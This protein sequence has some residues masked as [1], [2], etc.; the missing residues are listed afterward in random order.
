VGFRP[1]EGVK[2]SLDC[3]V[4]DFL[5]PDQL[6]ISLKGL[7]RAGCR[8]PGRE[9]RFVF[10]VLRI[11]ISKDLHHFTESESDLTQRPLL[12]LLLKTPYKYYCRRSQHQDQ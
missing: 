1:L 5:S 7:Y 11:Q 4:A 8:T 3:A 2:L 6:V 12:N 10:T 9:G